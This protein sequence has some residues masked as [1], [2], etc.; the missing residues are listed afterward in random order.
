MKTKLANWPAPKNITALT[1]TRLSG[2]SQAPYDSNNLGMNVGDQ[3]EHVLQNRQQLKQ[4]LQLPSEPQWLR[5]THSTDCVI[6]EEDSNREADA[7]ITRS[8]KHPLVI[9]TADCLPITLCN[10]QGTE[11]AAIHAGWKGLVNGII[12]NTLHKMHSPSSDLLAWIGPG[13]CQKCYEVDDQVYQ[14]FTQKYP[15]SKKAFQSNHT[16][17]LASLSQIAELVLQSHGV[18]LVYQSKL[19][20]FELES[21]LYSYRRSPQTGRI[22]TLIWFNDSSKD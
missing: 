11:I 4:L 13:I 9:L 16:K 7:A 22:G 3:E 20:T 2:F 19:C 10:I 5:Q 14:K 6:V 1:T 12:E 8:N 18:N 17:W 21:E 15:A